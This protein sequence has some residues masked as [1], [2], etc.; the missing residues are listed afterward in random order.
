MR[1]VLFEIPLPFGDAKLPIFGFGLM[2][3]VS[4]VVC[5][6][7]AARRAK[8]DGIAPDDFWD[9]A[10]WLF[11]GGVIGA[12]LTSLLLDGEPGGFWHQVLQFFKIWEGG[13]V[14]YG[15]LPGGLIAYLF[16]RKR[17]IRPKGIR[18]AQL[19]DII[20][21]M[22]GLGLF[23][24]RIGC[25]LN[26]CCYGLPAD[27]N[28]AAAWQQV[29]F[30]NN[31]IPHRKLVERGLQLGYGFLLAEEDLPPQYRAADPRTILLVAPGS[32]AEAAG[33]RAGDV[34]VKVG[35]ADTA[36]SLDLFKALR[37]WPANEPMTVTVVRGGQTRTVSFAPPRSRPFLPTQLYSSLDGLLLFLV[38]WFYYPFR[39]REGAV[40]ALMMILHGISRFNLERLRSDNPEFFFGMS[41]SQNVS[42][43]MLIG[44]AL[45]MY[46]VQRYGR[47]PGPPMPPPE[48]QVGTKRPVAPRA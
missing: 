12:R 32:A 9:I 15:C 43:A 24:G 40:F 39:R 28:L 4:F 19:A 38:L 11:V 1:Q 7:L 2:L 27:P 10:L 34:V 8:A 36:T 33:L 17:I 48:A 16:V 45:L 23:F 20:A 35:Q 21:P 31:S 46:W 18:L 3:L 26:G 30:P 14:F 25:F 13:M 6:W 5:G 47:I 42:I 29:T 44:G 37:L 22:L 41:V